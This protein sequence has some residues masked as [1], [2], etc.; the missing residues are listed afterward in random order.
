MGNGKVC[1][2]GG[3]FHKSLQLHSQYGFHLPVAENGDYWDS[4]GIY[5]DWDGNRLCM[6]GSKPSG[7]CTILGGCSSRW[8][9]CQ[10]A[11]SVGVRIE[12]GASIWER[13][14]QEPGR[15]LRKSNCCPR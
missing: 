2:A 5:R 1:E 14:A 10:S 4:D 12:C 8:E 11:D 13:C 7:T 15:I 9:L 3:N 6:D